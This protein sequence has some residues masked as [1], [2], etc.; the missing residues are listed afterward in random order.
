MTIDA[1]SRCF[2]DTSPAQPVFR[3]ARASIACNCDLVNSEESAG[4][5]PCRST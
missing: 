5:L 2:W 3:T 1:I 4:L